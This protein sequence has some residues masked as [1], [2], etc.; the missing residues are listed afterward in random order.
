MLFEIPTR[1]RKG[2]ESYVCI[3]CAKKI[4]PEVFSVS[5]EQSHSRVRGALKSATNSDK[6]ATSRLYTLYFFRPETVNTSATF[7]LASSGTVIAAWNRVRLVNARRGP[8]LLDFEGSGLPISVATWP[9]SAER[10]WLGMGR[11]VHHH[12]PPTPPLVQM[13]ATGSLW[14]YAE[15]WRLPL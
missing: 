4:G 2:T 11:L 3:R 6:R 9:A 10:G 8:G 7:G 13:D 12:I 14:S 5:Q 1:V 15:W